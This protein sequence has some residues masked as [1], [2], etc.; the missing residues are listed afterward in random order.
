MTDEE[1]GAYVRSKANEFAA[2]CK[3]FHDYLAVPGNAFL[4]SDWPRILE[5]AS[6]DM[7]DDIMDAVICGKITHER[8]GEREEKQHD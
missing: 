3:Q 6:K 8:L 4:G 2:L 5:R 1:L 7:I